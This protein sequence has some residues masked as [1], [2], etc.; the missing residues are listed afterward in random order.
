[1][2]CQSAPGRVIHSQSSVN[3]KLQVLIAFAAVSF[4]FLMNY[5]GA[6]EAFLSVGKDTGAP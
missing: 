6:V 5:H 2:S 3:G 1:M 4:R